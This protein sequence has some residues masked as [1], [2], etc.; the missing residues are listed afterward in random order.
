MIPVESGSHSAMSPPVNCWWFVA[1]WLLQPF[2]I[3]GMWSRCTGRYSVSR[4]TPYLSNMEKVIQEGFFS[5]FSKRNHWNSLITFKACSAWII[6]PHTSLTSLNKTNKQTKKRT[7][8]QHRCPTS[9]SQI[10]LTYTSAWFVRQLVFIVRLCHCRNSKKPR[11]STFSWRSSMRTR[12]R[13]LSNSPTAWMTSV[14]RWN[15]LFALIYWWIDPKTDRQ[16]RLFDGFREALHTEDA[17]I[18]VH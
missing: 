2:V 16:M 11:N 4:L 9:V 5:V 13:T 14:L 7:G 12:R 15:I 18:S 6:W 1:K 3:G 10:F 8:Q 17:H